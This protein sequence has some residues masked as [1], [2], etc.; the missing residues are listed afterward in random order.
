MKKVTIKANEDN[1]LKYRSG[2]AELDKKDDS[3]FKE[4]A[5]NSDEGELEYFTE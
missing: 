4:T 3:E 2:I 1:D 5:Y